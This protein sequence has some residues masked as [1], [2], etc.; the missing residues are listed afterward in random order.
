MDIGDE[1]QVALAIA[2]CQSLIQK[3]PSSPNLRFLLGRAYLRNHDQDSAIKEFRQAAGQGPSYAEPRLALAELSRQRR[4][5]GETVR[6]ANEVLAIDPTNFRARVLHA[7]GSTGLG[8]FDIAQAELT[9]LNREHPNSPDVA[10]ETGLLTMARKPVC[11][12]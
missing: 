6:L 3:K 5:F 11:G 1:K 2:E 12:R 8:N 9:A 7:S 4:D 10:L